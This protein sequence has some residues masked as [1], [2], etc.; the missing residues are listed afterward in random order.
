MNI[1]DLRYLLAVSKYK[2]F[3]LA[4][5][6]MC[7]SQSSLSKH[8]KN[9]EE[10]FDTVFIDRKSRILALTEAGHD[11]IEHAIKI[12]NDYND[13][14]IAMKKHSNLKKGRISLATIPVMSQYGLSPIIVSFSTAFPHIQIEMTEKENNFILEMIRNSAIDVAI[15][16]MNYIPQGLVDTYP[17]VEDEL[18]LVT[19]KNHHIAERKSISL[20]EVANEHFI[21]L[22]PESGIYHTC[23]QECKNFQFSPKILY[24][25]SR[26]ETI[27]GLVAEGVGVSL[28]MKKVIE[29]FDPSKLSII[30]LNKK[31]ASTLALVTPK[32][33]KVSDGTKAFIDFVTQSNVY[34]S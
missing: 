14:V 28:L 31:V 19:S 7:I 11:F 17:L 33:K 25:N 30:Q 29:P 34:H 2:S 24:T 9:L 3:S 22:N 16:R 5:D 1:E 6:E 26:I 32:H 20:E 10:E 13:M 12:L 4:A 15:M 21:L 8:I 18:V 23:V 27:L